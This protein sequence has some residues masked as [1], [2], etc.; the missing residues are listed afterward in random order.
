MK[1]K[2][3]GFLV[4][5]PSITIND[6]SYC[7]V[8]TG[9]WPA[10]VWP[11]S[12]STNQRYEDSVIDFEKVF[13]LDMESAV[14]YHRCCCEKG[15]PARLLYCESATE[16]TLY[17]TTSSFAILEKSLFL[18]YD[19]AYPNGDYYSAI[20]NDIIYRNLA[21]SNRWKPLLNKHGLF[22]S[23]ETISAFSKDRERTSILAN[24]D[25]PYPVYELGQ[26]SIFRIFQIGE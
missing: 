21:F 13:L 24:K 22:S 20:V 26:F 16:G 2:S 25:S 12:E 7:G 4:V 1:Y 10:D 6:I 15:I 9:V 8:D 19:Y 23:L 11:F 18:G 5:G 17:E 14:K 3:N